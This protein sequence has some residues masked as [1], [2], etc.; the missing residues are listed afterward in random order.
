MVTKTSSFIKPR[1]TSKALVTV[2]EKICVLCKF[3][4]PAEQFYVSVRSAD[5]LNRYCVSCCKVNRALEGVR[6]RDERNKVS[7]RQVYRAKALGV[8]YDPDVSLV[9]V[10]RRHR[11]ICALCETW[12][13][14][15][16]ASMDH[17]IPLSR[18]GNHLYDNVQ[19]THLKCNLK[20]GNRNSVK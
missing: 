14:P 18:G 2:T 12:V 5:G 11:G 3:T 20:K 16:V 17:T 1:N 9:E 13:S 10:F 4:L 8:Q 19:L 6:A 15:K 7:N